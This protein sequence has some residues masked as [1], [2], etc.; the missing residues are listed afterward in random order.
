MSKNKQNIY[1]AKSQKSD[2]SQSKSSN[3]KK[4]QQQHQQQQQ[5][6]QQ[7]GSNS[8]ESGVSSASD[9]GSSSDDGCREL[10]GRSVLHRA[11]SAPASGPPPPPPPPPVIL[12][13][14]EKQDTDKPGKYIY[15]FYK[16]FH[17]KPSH[18]YSNTNKFLLLCFKMHR[19][20]LQITNR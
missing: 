8:G 11:A 9:V 5:Q 20:Y 3:Q 7:Q 12:N 19:K 13:Q 15:L 4:S 6:Q 18:T 16:H 17:T 2:K 1:G 10:G 14:D